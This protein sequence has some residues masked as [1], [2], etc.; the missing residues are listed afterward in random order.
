M[1]WLFQSND[2][3]YRPIKWKLKTTDLE[4]MSFFSLTTTS[5]AILLQSGIEGSLMTLHVDFCTIVPNDLVSSRAIKIPVDV[6]VAS[7]QTSKA[8]TKTEI[9]ILTLSFTQTEN[10]LN[11]SLNSWVSKGLLL[12]FKTWIII[13][14]LS[15]ISLLH[16]QAWIRPSSLCGILTSRSEHKEQRDQCQAFANHPIEEVLW[17]HCNVLFLRRMS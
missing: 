6:P 4:P 3:S 14:E 15:I 11:F 13:L 8:C 2:I 1:S 17:E 7:T 9:T 16:C 5:F 12:I 10:W